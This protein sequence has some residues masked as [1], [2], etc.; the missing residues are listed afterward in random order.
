DH[1]QWV[2][3]ASDRSVFCVD[4]EHYDASKG[5]DNLRWAENLVK[6][7]GKYP[8]DS[9]RGRPFLTSDTV[10]VPTAWALYTIPIRT[11]ASRQRYPRAGDWD[12]DKEGPGN[13]LVTQDHLIIAGP[14]KVNVYTD[15]TVATRKLDQAIGAAPNDP[16]P[17]LR[18][19][20][21][22]FVAGRHADAGSKLD[23]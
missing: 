3:L 16:E 20:E 17:R 19:A 1:G 11:G 4:W 12:D 2:V 13:V 5:I 22:L 10:F 15:L 21:I 9:I 18:Y 23:E 8:S 6:G 14:Q 7:G